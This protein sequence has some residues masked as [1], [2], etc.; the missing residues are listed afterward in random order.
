[1]TT[2]K[3]ELTAGQVLAFKKIAADPGAGADP[4]VLGKLRRDGYVGKLVGRDGQGRKKTTS[5]RMM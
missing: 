1:M 3:D 4:G 5:P 2:E